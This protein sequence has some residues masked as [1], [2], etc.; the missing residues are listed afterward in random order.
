MSLWAW[1]A[2]G[3]AGMVVLAGA[4]IFVWR[5]LNP[6]VIPYVET[7]GPRMVIQ[8]DVVN[9]SNV[10]RAG[11]RVME[12]L[13]ERGFDVVELSTATEL[14]DSSMVIDRLGDRTSALKVAT[15]LGIADSMVVSNLD[16]MLFV[17]ASVIVG[18][19]LRSLEPFTEP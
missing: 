10:S 6:P 2:L 17:R 12:F 13:R 14:A 9:A 19:D 15:V 3:G 16:S 11:K 5:L 7:E 18:K 8:V 1:I 4:A